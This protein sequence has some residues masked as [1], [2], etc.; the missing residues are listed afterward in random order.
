MR[1][2]QVRRAQCCA[3]ALVMW[4]VEK[5][6]WPRDQDEVSSIPTYYLGR[7]FN[8][9]GVKEVSNA[10]RQFQKGPRLAVTK[11]CLDFG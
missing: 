7:T 11:G 6:S 8:N 2:S 10:E 5:M 9:T 4:E 3:A 1:Q